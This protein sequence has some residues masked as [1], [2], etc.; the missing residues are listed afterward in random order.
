MADQHAPTPEAATASTPPEANAAPTRNRANLV[1]GLTLILVGALFLGQT[2]GTYQLENWWALFLLIPTFAA[3]GGAY[4]LFR[5]ENR[6]AGAAWGAFIG[7]L[8]PLAVAIIFLYQLEWA[9]VW[10]VFIILAGLAAL[11][12]RRH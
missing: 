7:G 8:F 10:P 4:R 11:N 6:F 5:S 2:Y 3:W 9:Q 1:P 12:P